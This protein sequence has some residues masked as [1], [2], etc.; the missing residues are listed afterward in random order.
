MLEPKARRLTD[1]Y[2]NW[3]AKGIF[4]RLNKYYGESLSLFE[5]YS[6][7]EL[8][9]D[10]FGNHSGK[11]ATSPLIDILLCE[12]DLDELDTNLKNRLADIIYVK[13]G[14]KWNKL[15]DTLVAEY[16]PI[17]NYNMVEVDSPNYENKIEGKQNSQ[18]AISGSN[19]KTNKLYGFN[20]TEAVPVSTE[21]G[22]IAQTT[23]GRQDLNYQ[24][25]TETRKGS[26]TLTRR[27]NIGVTTTQQMLE[28]ERRLWFWSLVEQAFEDVDEILTS[29]YYIEEGEYKNMARPNNKS[30][31]LVIDLQGKDIAT[32][33]TISGIH[34][35]LEENAEGR[36]KPI[37]IANV[38]VSATEY[39]S[40]YVEA[41]K[42]STSW[43]LFNSLIQVTISNA[44]SVTGVIAS[45]T[46]YANQQALDTLQAKKLYCHPILVNKI[47]SHQF[48]IF[49]FNN[50]ATPF[51]TWE[52]VVAYIKGISIAISGS[53]RFPSTGGL[54]TTYADNPYVCAISHLYTDS[55]GTEINAQG[56][57]PDNSRVNM[58][59]DTDT[60]SVYDGVNEI[61]PNL[62]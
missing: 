25:S 37:L 48:C 19:G 3:L 54:L 4:Y 23:S 10:Y 32:A 55:N 20:S 41:K 43:V 22:S 27:G 44:D 40:M 62:A 42:V 38:I 17:D 15:Y 45:K 21:E 5:I 46:P 33:K 57:L 12:Y 35:A 50:D 36:N 34:E 52:G 18:I 29:N 24:E 49:I 30:G 31:Y 28:S 14:L 11:K 39:P 6:P 2:D 47:N 9:M 8:D 56:I 59:V 16:N 7:L 1:V 13:Y 53:A 61:Y 51:T 58:R 60:F 26:K